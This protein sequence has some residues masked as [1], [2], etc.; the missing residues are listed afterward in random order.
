MAVSAR[1]F[2]DY[3]SALLICYEE[4]VSGEGYFAG[5]ADQ[6]TGRP[7][8]ALLM[9]AHMERVT[10]AVLRPLIAVHGLRTED[11]SALLARGRAEAGRQQGITWESLTRRMAEDY[12]VYMD[13]FDQLSRLAPEAD[14]VTA[15]IASDHEQALIDFARLETA[16][17]PES[18]KPIEKFLARHG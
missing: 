6:F 10:A 14:Q 18:L 4:E 15:S 3:H 16:G 7:R 2:P 12:H 17:D 13:E 8:E 9:I 11:Q 1:I 5:L